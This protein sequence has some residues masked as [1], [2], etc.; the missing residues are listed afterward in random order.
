M[1]LNFHKPNKNQFHNDNK[2]S[3]LLY[4]QNNT[5]SFNDI[6]TKEMDEYIIYLITQIYKLYEAIMRA[7]VDIAGI[8]SPGILRLKEESIEVLPSES[9]HKQYFNT[10]FFKDPF[11]KVSTYI[12]IKTLIY[13]LFRVYYI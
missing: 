10:V 2:P 8:F 12:I 3:S 1:Y 6:Y 5:Y 9:L 11:F 13:N 4:W 7:S